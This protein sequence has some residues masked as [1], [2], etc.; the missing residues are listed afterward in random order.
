MQPALISISMSTNY[1]NK[2]S[3][4]QNS[5]PLV[6]RDTLV[7]FPLTT[8]SNSVSHASRRC[9]LSV[10]PHRA[11]SL[12]CVMPCTTRAMMDVKARYESHASLPG[13]AG[14]S[15]GKQ[16]SFSHA[17]NRHRRRRRHRSFIVLA[18]VPLAAPRYR[19]SPS[20]VGH[21]VSSTLFCLR[22]PLHLVW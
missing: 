5:S 20:A 10:M 15:E 22:F 19:S 3:H 4:Y 16:F 7:N 1:G 11:I 13:S 12:A 18:S 9:H 14:Q 21:F 17:T 6:E 2:N 8:G